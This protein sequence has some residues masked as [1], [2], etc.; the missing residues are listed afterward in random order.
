MVAF[1]VVMKVLGIVAEAPPVHDY[2]PFFSR[3]Q[4]RELQTVS[5]SNNIDG[6]KGGDTCGVRAAACTGRTEP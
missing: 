5:G 6:H 2:Q 4:G 3:F 1:L